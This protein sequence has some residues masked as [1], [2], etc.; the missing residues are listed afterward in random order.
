MQVAP[1][2]SAKGNVS[3]EPHEPIESSVKDEDYEEPKNEPQNEG[4]TSQAVVV[5][6]MTRTTIMIMMMIVAVEVVTVMMMIYPT[7]SSWLFQQRP[8]VILLR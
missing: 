8:L 3:S 7:K 1:E 6:R 2:A 4:Y 5:T